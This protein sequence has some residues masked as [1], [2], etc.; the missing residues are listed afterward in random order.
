MAKYKSNN[1]G[2]DCTAAQ[3]LAELMCTRQAQRHNVDLP[4]KFWNLDIWKK[5]YMTELFKAYALLKLYP[6]EVVVKA[7]DNTTWLS[8]LLYKD[9]S[10]ILDK[11]QDKQNHLKKQAEQAKTFEETKTDEA[12]DKFVNKKS[13]LSRLRELDE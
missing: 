1:S 6:E 4:F 12:Q 9:I 7:I 10:T 13:K 11:E 2:Q 5:P 8:T 3:Y